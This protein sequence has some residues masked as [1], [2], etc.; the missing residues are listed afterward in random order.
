[1]TEF[2]WLVAAIPVLVPFGLLIARL[3]VGPLPGGRHRL[4]RSH[5]GWEA[6]PEQLA[7]LSAPTRQ[8]TRRG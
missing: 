3:V 4:S 8:E 6:H 5:P 7:E 1:M 2:L